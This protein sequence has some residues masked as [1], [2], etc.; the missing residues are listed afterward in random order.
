LAVDLK[1]TLLPWRRPSP[2]PWPKPHLT[3]TDPL[4]SVQS[5]SN[6][7]LLSLRP[8]DRYPLP[9]SICATFS[10]KTGS[11]LQF[12]PSSTERPSREQMKQPFLGSGQTFLPSF[13][14][15]NRSAPST[16]PDENRDLPFPAHHPAYLTLWRRDDPPSS[17]DSPKEAFRIFPPPRAQAFSVNGDQ[18]A[19]GLSPFPF[20]PPLGRWSREKL[21]QTSSSSRDDPPFPVAGTVR[22][23]PL[24]FCFWDDTNLS[25]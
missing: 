5:R 22:G 17:P 21:G 11:S 3:T 13:F 2:P 15:Q 9:V 24:F 1:A 6:K 12:S 10:L 8:R 16:K 7:L 4:P 19:P 14:R 23:H 18:H 25:L 20:P